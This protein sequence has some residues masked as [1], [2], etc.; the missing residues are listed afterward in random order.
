MTDIQHANSSEKI[1]ES[2]AID[3]PDSRTFCL[4]D[5]DGN[6]PRVRDG[7]AVNLS[8]SS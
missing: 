4:I 5:R 6:A 1:Q 7:I 3:I 8:L 2:V